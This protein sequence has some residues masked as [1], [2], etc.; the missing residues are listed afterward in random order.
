MIAAPH[1]GLRFPAVAALRRLAR[2]ARFVGAELALWGSIYLG[3][4][5]VR[6]ATVGGAREAVANAR[7]LLALEG[8]I[9]IGHEGRVQDS[10]GFAHEALSAY[11]MA[12]F[13]P[14]IVGVLVWT[15]IHR[16][17]VYRRLRTLLLVS[18]TL[19]LI[20]YVFYPTAP[21]RLVPELGMADTVGLSSGHDNGSFAGVRFN[22]YAA[23]P[24]MHVGWSLLVGIVGFAAA[25]R[26]L[27]R[28]L[29]VAHPAVMTVTVTATGNHYFVDSIAGALVALA[30]I[31]V[32]WAVTRRPRRARAHV[33]AGSSPA[34]TLRGW[35]PST[36]STAP[37][38]AATT[39]ELRVSQLR[40]RAGPATTPGRSPA[41]AASSTWSWTAR[42]CS[43]RSAR[44]ASRA[45][46][47][48]SS[49]CSHG[50][51]PALARLR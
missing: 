7:D 42:R 24:S 39:G 22:P 5:A 44:V 48:S 43:P 34:P 14:L 9:G 41:P 20:G 2:P 1:T 35:R 49:G 6:G 47:R 31:A 21:P 51:R 16:R 12:G 30:G 50:R 8:A 23:M 17:D 33:G 25:R 36:S 45:R 13:A 26:R 28:V 37:S 40:S 4:L 10:L 3:Y 27:V 32:V 15:A 11:Y 19:A 38:E 18:I 46:P 29:S